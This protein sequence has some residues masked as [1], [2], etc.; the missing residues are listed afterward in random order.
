MGRQDSWHF[1]THQWYSSPDW[2]GRSF[3]KQSSQMVEIK[4]TTYWA[5]RCMAA[6]WSPAANSVDDHRDVSSLKLTD[7]DNTTKHEMRWV[8]LVQLWGSWSYATWFSCRGGGNGKRSSL[9]RKAEDGRST[10]NAWS[11]LIQYY[12]TMKS[13]SL[14]LNISQFLLHSQDSLSFIWV[15]LIPKYL[16]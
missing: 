1:M 12:E 7:T 16:N 15:F 10:F 6:L 13:C 2:S 4:F 5:S 14:C 9:N 11:C 3:F 8:D